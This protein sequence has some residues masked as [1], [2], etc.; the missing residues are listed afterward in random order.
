MRYYE[1]EQCDISRCKGCSSCS[2]AYGYDAWRD[3]CMELGLERG[4]ERGWDYAVEQ[5]WT[6]GPTY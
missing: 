6:R 2:D 3:G 4:D 1:D 5:G